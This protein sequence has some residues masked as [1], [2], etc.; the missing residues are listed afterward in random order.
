MERIRILYYASLGH[1]NRFSTFVRSI[2][3]RLTDF[4]I[5]IQSLNIGGLI[6]NLTED[7]NFDMVL[8]HLTSSEMRELNVLRTD[9]FGKKGLFGVIEHSRGIYDGLI[10]AESRDYPASR[11][12]IVKIFDDYIQP[13]ENEIYL[14]NFVGFLKRH[15]LIP[16]DFEL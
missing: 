15:H 10:V 6:T 2:N 16:Q 12:E 9:Y 3:E 8:V 1:V 7:P 5:D 4:K 14:S 13:V 11:E